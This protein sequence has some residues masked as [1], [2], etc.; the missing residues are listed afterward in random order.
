[1]TTASAAATAQKNTCLIVIDGWG[2][3]TDPNTEGDAIRNAQVPVMT[4]LQK[5]YP[6]IP[7]LAHGEAVGLVEG[8]MGNSEV[9]HLNI[10]AGRIVYQ[11]I[12][13]INKAVRNK[14][15]LE[16]PN[17]KKAFQ[18]CVDGNGRLHLLG[19]VSDGGVHGHINHLFALLEEAQAFGIRE[20]YVHFFG[21]G[22]DTAPTSA[23]LYLKQLQDKLSALRYGT[24]ATIVGRYYAM[25]RDNRWERIK[26]AYD[27]L[28]AGVGEASTDPNATILERYAQNENDEFLKPI[29][30]SEAGR[31]GDNDHLIFFNYRSDRMRQINEA[32]GVARHFEPVREPR[33]LHITTMTRYNDAFP[34]PI[35]FP[36]QTMDNVLA[37]W[38]GKLQ[39]PQCHIAETEKYAHV[40]FFFNGGK[41]AMYALEQRDLVPSPKVATYDLKPEMSAAGVAEKVAERVRAKQHPFVMC[42]F[43][44]PDMVGHTGVYEATIKACEAT[45]A[46]IGLILDACL[47]TG[48]TLFITS[49]HGNAEKMLNNGKPHTAHTVNRVP[50]IMV[51]PEA[52]FV[53]R[54]DA[55]LCDV[56]PTM[57]AYMGLDQPAEMEGRSLLA[58]A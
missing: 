40:T 31:I 10:G 37:E 3:S 53:D 54:D 21:D 13:R 7:I 16:Q 15:L 43:A 45:D 19:L 6:T 4:R 23:V 11:D 50:F 9:G 32:F 56:A 48:T 58:R 14:A 28:V 47:E 41:E 8:L 52:R 29:I 49:D 5:E 17:L 36:P 1:M 18:Q 27:G 55:A 2:L 12:V 25:D 24:L 33:D 22:R 51:D 44:P 20:C 42:N 46:G 38:L 30:V 34:M 57:L 26:I 35:I 39:I